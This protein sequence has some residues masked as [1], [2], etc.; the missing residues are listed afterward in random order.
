MSKSITMNKD[1]IVTLRLTACMFKKTF[2]EL[3]LVSCTSPAAL[4][5][6]SAP[7]HFFSNNSY[8]FPGSVRHAHWC[9][10]PTSTKAKALWRVK[11]KGRVGRWGEG[12]RSVM[13]AMTVMMSL[14]QNCVR[15]EWGVGW[16]D[17]KIT[18]VGRLKLR[19]RRRDA[20][21]L[22]LLF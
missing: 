22:Q 4:L 14:C 3:L 10:W 6:L 2:K 18:R 7:Q 13:A 17:L 19:T 16:G 21:K 5:L 15:A 8:L 12:G 9:E 11:K 1:V 20:S